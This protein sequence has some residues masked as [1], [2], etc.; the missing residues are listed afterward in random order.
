MQLLADLRRWPARRWAVALIGGMA[1][2]VALAIPTALVDNPFYTRMTPVTWW[3]WPVWIA[4]GVLGGLVL[5]TYVRDPGVR[6]RSAGTAVSG[7]ILS[8]LAVGCPVCNKLVVLA[9]GV[10]GAMQLWAPVQPILGLASVA[11]L[12]FALWRRLSGE[13]A[14]RLSASRTV[15][16]VQ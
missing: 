1:T 6:T 8:F 16:A 4:T 3:S 14:C 13:R 10:S 9:L 2:A 7:G 11:L 12:G 5:A 15:A